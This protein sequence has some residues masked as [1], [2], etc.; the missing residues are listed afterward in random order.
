MDGGMNT[1]RKLEMVG[2]CAVCGGRVK[3]QRSTQNK[4]CSRECM[5]QLASRNSLRCRKRKPYGFNH[6]QADEYLSLM[7]TAEISP[8]SERDYWHSEARK[9]LRRVVPNSYIE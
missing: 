2:H 5:S 7:E 4:T 9:L 3:R 6:D 1:M 8:A